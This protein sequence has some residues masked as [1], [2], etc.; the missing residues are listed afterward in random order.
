MACTTCAGAGGQWREVRWCVQEVAED[1]GSGGLMTHEDVCAAD[2]V[3]PSRH[4]AP[5]SPTT[6][7]PDHAYEQVPTTCLAKAEDHG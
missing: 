1:L 6:F 7:V 4:G 2:G 3:R 5:I